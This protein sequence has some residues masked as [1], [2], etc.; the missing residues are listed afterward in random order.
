M[1]NHIALIHTHSS[2][3]LSYLDSPKEETCSPSCLALAFPGT[4]DGAHEEQVDEAV[5]GVDGV[6]GEGADF[7]D[8]VLGEG[9]GDEAEPEDG[10]Y[11]DAAEEGLFARG[12][13][14][15]GEHGG[16][17]DGAEQG[18]RV[19]QGR[20]D[21]GLAHEPFHGAVDAGEPG[22]EEE[23]EPAGFEEEGCEHCDDEG[24]PVETDGAHETSGG[25]RLCITRAGGWE[26]K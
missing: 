6:E 11:L 13:D 23:A 15:D 25:L 18:Y 2:K 21:V 3:S 5:A 24:W 22:L 26:G 17:D 19:L 16:G 20:G 7:E 8:V 10:A 12:L 4:D 9:G 1:R 14:A